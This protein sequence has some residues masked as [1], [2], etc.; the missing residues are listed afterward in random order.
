VILHSTCFRQEVRG[1]A[2]RL[3]ALGVAGTI[4][5]TAQRCHAE[6]YYGNNGGDKSLVRGPLVRGT[7]SAAHWHTVT[8]QCHMW[9]VGRG[10]GR[11]HV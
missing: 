6:R 11:G 1:A 8:C 5:G 2:P 7:T 9:S 4:H 10:G 3:T